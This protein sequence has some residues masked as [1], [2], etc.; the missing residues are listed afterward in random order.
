VDQVKEVAG[1]EEE[2]DEQARG[3]GPLR[4]LAFLLLAVVL[5]VLS[6]GPVI[7]LCLVSGKRVPPIIDAAYKPLEFCYRHSDI[8]HG[9]F[10]WY[11]RVCGVK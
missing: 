9:F 1:S 6:T 3:G 11:F 8:A 2:S 5:Y 10:D 4:V 7:K